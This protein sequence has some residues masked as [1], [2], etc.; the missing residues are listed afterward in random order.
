[1]KQLKKAL[2]QISKKVILATAILI[3]LNMTVP[4]TLALLS[5]SSGSDT[6]GSA[7]TTTVT[8]PNCNNSTDVGVQKCIATDP[9]VKDINLIVN[10][11]SAGVAIVVIGSII[12]GGIQYSLAGDNSTA[13]GAAKKRISDGLIALVA[14]IF[15]FAFLQWL[16]PGG[17]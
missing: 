9:I 11:L 12:V 16:I 2:K 6:S 13:T 4:S 3:C 14:F 8:N 17:L 7:T 1:M 15:T 10:F 5:N